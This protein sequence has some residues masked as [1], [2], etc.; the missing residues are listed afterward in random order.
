[1]EK[2]QEFAEK[3]K[4]KEKPRNLPIE[5]FSQTYGLGYNT[6]LLRVYDSTINQFY[7]NRL[8]QAMRFGEKIVIDC[9]YE[10]YM[11]TRE[12]TNCAKQLMLL[13]AEN[14]F[15]DGRYKNFHFQILN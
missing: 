5:E 2:A 14:R 8:I 10:S 1:M 6:I 9:S 15:H 13:F 11:T 12:S 4:N 7:N 3:L